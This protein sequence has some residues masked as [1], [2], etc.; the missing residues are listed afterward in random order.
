MICS[1]TDCQEPI[2]TIGFTIFN[3][4]SF[5]GRPY[6]WKCGKHITDY[7]DRQYAAGFNVQLEWQYLNLP[8]DIS[9]FLRLMTDIA[10]VRVTL[11]TSLMKSILRRTSFLT[12]KELYRFFQG[13]LVNI[14]PNEFNALCSLS[15]METCQL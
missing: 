10:V 12:R 4:G 8:M 15:P 6:C 11:Q 13:V 14:T 3:D 9:D 7:A 2:K 5:E 1:R